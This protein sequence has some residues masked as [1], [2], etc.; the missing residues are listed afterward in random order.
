MIAIPQAFSA[1]RSGQV[2]AALLAAN[3]VINAQ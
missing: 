1:V 2:D 3:F